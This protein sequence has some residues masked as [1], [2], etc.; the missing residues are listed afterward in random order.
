MQAVAGMES[1]SAEGWFYSALLPR[2]LALYICLCCVRYVHF[3]GQDRVRVSPSGCAGTPGEVDTRMHGI[4]EAHIGRTGEP[5]RGLSQSRGHRLHRGHP[6]T[7]VLPSKH[8]AQA[9]PPI[10]SVGKSTPPGLLRSAYKVGRPEPTTPNVIWAA[11][12]QR[13]R[14]GVEFALPLPPNKQSNHGH[15]HPLPRPQRPKVSRHSSVLFDRPSIH[16]AAHEDSDLFRVL[17]QTRS[18]ASPRHIIFIR[19]PHRRLI[20]PNAFLSTA[21]DRPLHWTLVGPYRT[22]QTTD[23]SDHP[24]ARSARL[25]PVGVALQEPAEARALGLHPSQHE[26]ARGKLLPFPT[27]PHAGARSSRPSR[28]LPFGAA[29]SSG[30]RRCDG[31][32]DGMA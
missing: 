21:S 15:I 31:R 6:R 20:R 22:T 10:P 8:S 27:M 11:K 2:V 16:S 28:F 4:G 3:Y 14:P 23:P 1:P 12:L 13:R 9:T 18:P 24:I 30:G 5:P 25:G 26:F 19:R 7:K 17:H 32:M 29:C